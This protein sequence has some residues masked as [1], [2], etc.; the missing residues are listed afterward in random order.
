M[1]YSWVKRA[2][3]SSYILHLLI[4]KVPFLKK[5]MAVSSDLQ[6]CFSFLFKILQLIVWNSI[7]RDF[8]RLLTPD[9]WHDRNKIKRL[10]QSIFCWLVFFK[11]K[12]CFFFLQMIDS[13]NSPEI[14]S[15]W[16][17]SFLEV[18]INVISIFFP[19]SF[20]KVPN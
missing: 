14:E 12:S 4:H 19:V 15:F 3:S 11:K 2:W 16:N 13:L 6:F 9:L 5:N 10:R 18:W 8:L 17:G 1:S 20:A 7:F